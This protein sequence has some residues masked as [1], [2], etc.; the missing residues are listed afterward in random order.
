MRP[1]RDIKRLVR[2]V[3]IHSTSEGNRAVFDDLLKELATSREDAPIL[4]GRRAWGSIVQHLV[5]RVSIAAA[6]VLIVVLAVISR[7]PHEPA[8][9]PPHVGTLSVADM[10]TV[11]RLNAACR[12]G[13]L[14]EVDKQCELAARRLQIRPERISAEQLIKEMKGT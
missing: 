12:R 9:Q 7:T 1:L 4:P 14:P 11:G 13:G 5:A 10:L 6:L 3:E 2:H 8:P